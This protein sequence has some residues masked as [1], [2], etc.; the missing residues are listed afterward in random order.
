MSKFSTGIASLAQA[1]KGTPFARTKF[2]QLEDGEEVIV[3]FL[4]DYNDVV[5]VEQHQG[6]SARP[7]PDWVKK[8]ANWPV[9]WGCVCRNSKMGDGTTRLWEV[10]DDSSDMPGCYVCDN[11]TGD[12]GKP[13]RAKARGWALVCLRDE[14]LGDGSDALGGPSMKGQIVSYRD[15]TRDVERDGKTVTEKDVQVANMSHKIFFALLEGASRRFG[16]LLDRDFA[17]ARVGTGLDTTYQIVHLDPIPGHDL[18]KP[19]IADLYKV[20]GYD[21]DEIVMG[22]SEAAY[23]RRFFDPTYTP[24]KD[25]GESS[26]DKGGA[27]AAEQAKPSGD[28]NQSQLDAMAAKI[29]GHR[30]PVS[31]DTDGGAT[32]GGLINV[33]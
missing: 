17:I 23:I 6:A 22:R 13:A 32:E 14:V 19:E 20:E 28:L 26:G 10:M 5:N 3:R 25:E 11:V 4:T 21:L 12:E 16:T 15:R 9:R 1:S 24:P 31:E 33:Q 27:P 18:R 2:F 8:E 30:A 7:R 29:Q